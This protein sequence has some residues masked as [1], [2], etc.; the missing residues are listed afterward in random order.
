MTNDS[1]YLGIQKERGLDGEFPFWC[2]VTPL[3]H[4][5]QKGL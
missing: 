2:S 5:T 1:F 3:L 4:H